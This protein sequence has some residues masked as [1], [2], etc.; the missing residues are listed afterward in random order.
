MSKRSKEQW[1]ALFDQHA[2]SGQS[3][4]QFC[5]QQGICAKHFSYRKKQLLTASANKQADT[6]RA[7]VKAS[8][9]S[10][11]HKAPPEVVLQHGRSH[12]TLPLNT[13]ANWLA[14]L[15]LALN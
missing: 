13:D 10:V 2:K 4:A 9:R 15:L 1:F 3:I 14:S 11:T 8:E 12:I 7:F 6:Q 5:K